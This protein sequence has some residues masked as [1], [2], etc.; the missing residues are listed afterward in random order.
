MKI[1]RNTI[2]IEDTDWT[3]KKAITIDG[4]TKI[5]IKIKADMMRYKVW[6]KLI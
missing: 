2:K 5:K 1:I 3:F 6:I 4:T